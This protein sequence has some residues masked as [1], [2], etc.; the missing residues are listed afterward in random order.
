MGGYTLHI[1]VSY[2]VVPAVPQVAGHARELNDRLASLNNVLSDLAENS[3]V[4]HIKFQT[5]SVELD[6]M[7]LVILVKL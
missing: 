6:K 5:K 1:G 7:H 2:G 4:A 3:I